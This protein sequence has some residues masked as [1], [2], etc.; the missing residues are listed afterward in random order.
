MKKIAIYTR[1]SR[2][3]DTGDSIGTQIKLVKDYFRNQ[4]CEFEIFEDEGFSGG[5]TNR[6]AFKLMMEKIKR[7]EFNAVAVYKIDRIARN[8][9]DFFKI[10]DTLEKENIA[11]V[12]VSEGFDPNTPGGRITMTMIAGIAEMERMNIKQRVTDNMIE[13]AKRG[14]W[15]GGNVPLGYEAVR[16]VENGKECSYLK[17]NED[18]KEIVQDIY[19]LFVEGYSIRKVA[20]IVGNKYN[21]LNNANRISFILYSPVYVSSCSAVN[22]FLE[23]KGWTI[24]GEVN[25]QGYLTYQKP[26]YRNG[27]KY[28]IENNAIA[29]ISKHDA[30]ISP[31]VW[32]KAQEKLKHITNDPSPRISQYTFLAKM[33]SCG[34]CGVHMNVGVSKSGG[35]KVFYFRKKCS[36]DHGSKK[37]SRLHIEK[38]EKTV[39]ETLKCIKNIGIEEYLK[40]FETE[41]TREK[42]DSLKI[43][44]EIAKIDKMVNNLTDKLALANENVVEV[45]M[46]KIS[47]LINNKKNL[48]EQLLIFE[49]RKSFE[50]IQQNNTRILENTITHFLEN[51]NE[52]SM[53]EKQI[54]I[55][56]IFH[57]FKWF[58]KDEKL[59]AEIM[60]L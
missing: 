23:L 15:T 46:D 60:T 59:K 58:G 39:L 43:Q 28:G 13:L 24:F 36:C 38:A 35:K 53:E 3:T 14:N 21:I 40:E 47:E 33:I 16:T 19:N 41:Q 2:I 31:N 12:S 32:L 26:Q 18:E 29:A 1:K 37:G 27:E 56:N 42:D 52:M 57:N 9:V 49:Q 30:I 50:S 54:D 6:P 55:K 5:N 22:K 20:N 11:L 34:Y 44:K 48:Q 45:L 10:F 7:K 51:F 4:E 25:G 17:I 8:I